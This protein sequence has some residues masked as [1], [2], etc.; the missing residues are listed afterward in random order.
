MAKTKATEHTRKDAEFFRVCS[1]AGFKDF[2]L[3]GLMWL[4][5]RSQYVITS[6]RSRTV[7][8]NGGK[9]EESTDRRPF[10]WGIGPDCVFAENNQQAMVFDANPSA[11]PVPNLD[12]L[13]VFDAYI[14]WLREQ[15]KKN[16]G[17]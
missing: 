14:S 10:S 1:A 9:D 12:K 6:T 5:S 2:S 15:A 3:F 7:I 13:K 11:R 16:G 17:Q 8:S 4:K